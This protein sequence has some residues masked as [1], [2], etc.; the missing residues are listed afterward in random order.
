MF[1][2]TIR[3]QGQIKEQYLLDDKGFVK[4]KEYFLN[5]GDMFA[6]NKSIHVKARYE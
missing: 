2:Y 3:I 1:L 4:L 5:W 6:W